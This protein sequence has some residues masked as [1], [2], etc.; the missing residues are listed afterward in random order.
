M[1]EQDACLEGF[2]SLN[3]FREY[4]AKSNAPDPTQAVKVITFELAS[5]KEFAEANT[6]KLLG[7]NK[8]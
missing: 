3:E 1:T 8:C 4:W 6:L 7:D 5:T 2:K